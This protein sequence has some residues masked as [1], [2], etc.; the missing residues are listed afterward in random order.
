MALC[1]VCGATI[2]GDFCAKCGTKQ[3]APLAAKKRHTLYWV[4]GGCL[5]RIHHQK[6]CDFPNF[7]YP[8]LLQPQMR[9][10]SDLQGIAG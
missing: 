7:N 1:K 8:L 2:E 6:I 4:L 9:N 5:S 3:S 10:R